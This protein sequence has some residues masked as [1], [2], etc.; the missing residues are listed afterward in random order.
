MSEQKNFSYVGE[1]PVIVVPEDT[2]E[3]TITPLDVSTD[4]D[5]TG[6]KNLIPVEIT[7]DLPRVTGKKILA[8]VDYSSKKMHIEGLDQA[9]INKI[10][11][12]F[13]KFVYNTGSLPAAEFAEN[14]PTVPTTPKEE[15]IQW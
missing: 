14:K 15:D 11:D 2:P 6:F 4:M 1:S 3:L 8:H 9:T 12:K 10:S 13:F 7:Y 5:I